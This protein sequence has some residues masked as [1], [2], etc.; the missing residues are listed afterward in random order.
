MAPWLIGNGSRGQPGLAG[1]APRSILSAAGCRAPHEVRRRGTPRLPPAREHEAERGEP[2]LPAGWA[3]AGDA[4]AGWGPS[5]PRAPAAA[6]SE[7]PGQARGRALPGS[8]LPEGEDEG[9]YL[10][11]S[12]RLFVRP[13]LVVAD[14]PPLYLKGVGGGAAASE[15]ASHLH[16]LARLGCHVVG[17]LS[18][19]GCG[20]Q[21]EGCGRRRG[22]VTTPQGTCH[23]PTG[24]ASPPRRGTMPLATPAGSPGVPG[25]F[26]SQAGL[27][28]RWPPPIP[29]APSPAR[30]S[31]LSPP[32]PPALCKE[33]REERQAEEILGAPAPTPPQGPPTPE[34][35]WDPPAPP[36]CNK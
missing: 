24:D 19:E 35:A 4:A 14:V 32:G 30:Q 3:S 29:S 17:G 11:G 27:A 15:G 28:P 13:V 7:A 6:A 34:Q 25:P 21:S 22:H 16:V 1:P 8:S 18:E 20:R 2:P 12:P 36:R 5:P 31:R 9:C 23:H 33:Q 10:V 26:P